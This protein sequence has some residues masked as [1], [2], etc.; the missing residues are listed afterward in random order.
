MQV[1]GRIAVIPW[2]SQCPPYID[3]SGSIVMI[4]HVISFCDIDWYHTQHMS[5]QEQ[6][7]QIMHNCLRWHLLPSQR[8]ISYEN[9]PLIPLIVTCDVWYDPSSEWSCTFGV[10]EGYQV[11]C[12]GNCGCGIVV[13]FN[14][15]RETQMGNE[16]RSKWVIEGVEWVGWSSLSSIISVFFQQTRR[17]HLR[18]YANS[19]DIRHHGCHDLGR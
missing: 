6:S 4:V 19:E 14:R 12:C 13:V 1:T 18:T 11:D 3:Q 17:L 5:D 10:F 9:N 7:S 2:F 8:T 15:N 16:W